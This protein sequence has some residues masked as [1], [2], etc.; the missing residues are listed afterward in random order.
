MDEVTASSD[1]VRRIAC[2]PQVDLPGT[3]FRYDNGGTHLLAA[4]LDAL[5]PQGLSRFAGSALFA[6][7]GVRD[8]QWRTDDRGLPYGHAHL[9]LD[10]DALGRLGQL[11]LQDGRWQD[12]VLVD[13]AF[14]AAMTT[15]HSTGGPPELLP[16]GYLLWLDGGNPLAGGW[17]GQ[18][19]LVHRRSR[20]VVVVTGD[21]GFR[22]GP[23]P[24]DDLPADWRPA[25]ELVRRHLLPVLDGDHPSGARPR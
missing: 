1:Q 12:R 18:H 10:A 8:W 4:V 14:S 24:G 19:V 3:V 15:P 22:F 7:L 16:Y 13:G 20:A 5:V 21:P 17:A 9:E 11:W 25:L 6:P 23:P 2:A